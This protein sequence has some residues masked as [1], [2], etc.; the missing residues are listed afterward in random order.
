MGEF[1][2]IMM[3]PAVSEK[4]SE[5]ATQANYVPILSKWTFL[6]IMP[7]NLYYAEP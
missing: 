6:V 5:I 2:V 3:R 7:A 4:R 1:V